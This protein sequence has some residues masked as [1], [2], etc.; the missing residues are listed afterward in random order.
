[1]LINTA[2]LLLRE[3]DK[4]KN[5]NDNVIESETEFRPERHE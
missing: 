1:M 3:N 2:R 4:N 5:D